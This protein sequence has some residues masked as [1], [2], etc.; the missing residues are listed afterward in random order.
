M[1]MVNEYQQIMGAIPKANS[2]TMK[3]RTWMSKSVTMPGMR[4]C[5]RGF[6]MWPRLR[7]MT[8]EKA[9]VKTTNN[10]YP[11]RKAT[12]DR[13]T[14]SS[15]NNTQLRHKRMFKRCLMTCGFV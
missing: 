4:L 1:K 2:S 7:S 3:R 9:K 13:W 5:L 8:L 6:T 12:W 10:S 11:M 14:R 15:S